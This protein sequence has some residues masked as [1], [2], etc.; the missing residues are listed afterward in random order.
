VDKVRLMDEPI[1]E[2]GTIE[3]SVRESQ[4]TRPGCVRMN[5]AT[6]RQ[7]GLDPSHNKIDVMA[8][9]ISVTRKVVPD[10]NVGYQDIFLRRDARIALH[11]SEHDVVSVS[12][13][14]P[15]GAAARERLVLPKKQVEIR[16]KTVV[17]E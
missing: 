11:V 4:I 5:S 1:M 3:L 12:R 7:L 13:H 8:G 9:N 10:D 6:Y 2:F 17:M 14:K 15:F 16:D